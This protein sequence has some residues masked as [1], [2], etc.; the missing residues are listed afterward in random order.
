MLQFVKIRDLYRQERESIFISDDSHQLWDLTLRAQIIDIRSI[1]RWFVSPLYLW[2]TGCLIVN[3][4]KLIHT[5]TYIG[6]NGEYVVGYLPL[7]EVI[8]NHTI[9]E[10]LSTNSNSFQNTIASQLM[11][12][13]SCINN[14]SLFV[15]VRDHTSRTKGTEFQYFQGNHA[16]YFFR[17]CTAVIR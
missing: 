2:R 11:H 15:S 10:S 8:I 1:F 3:D 16:L 7:L 12:H 9:W 4:L 5:Y 13:Q 14:T 6:N 17:L